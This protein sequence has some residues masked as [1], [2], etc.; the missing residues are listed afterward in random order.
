MLGVCTEAP[1]RRDPGPLSDRLEKKEYDESLS[2]GVPEKCY[3]L[4]WVFQRESRNYSFGCFVF[5]AESHLE[6]KISKILI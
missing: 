5:F 6:L 1:S 3:L 4:K 2:D